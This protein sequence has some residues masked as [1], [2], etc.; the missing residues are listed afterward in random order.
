MHS[1]DGGGA[2]ALDGAHLALEFQ[3]ALDVAQHDGAGS[4]AR[5]LDGAVVEDASPQVLLNEDALDLTDDNLV[6]MAVNPSVA[7]E[8]PLVAHKDGRGQVAHEV[9]QLQVGPLAESGLVDD[10][11]AGGND[12]ADFHN[13][14]LKLVQTENKCKYI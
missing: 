14:S 6:G 9:S 11:F 8:E 13:I 10:G 3:R 7:V 4:R 1:L 5:D 12:S 2:G